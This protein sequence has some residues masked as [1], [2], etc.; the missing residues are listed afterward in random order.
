MRHFYSALCFLALLN[1]QVRAQT[2]AAEDA[3]WVI[4]A[5]YVVTMDA[6]HH[7]IDGGALAIRGTRTVGVGP[8]SEIGRRFQPRHIG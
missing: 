3:D 8:Q 1:P 6:Q 7:I 5:K 2:R 4:R